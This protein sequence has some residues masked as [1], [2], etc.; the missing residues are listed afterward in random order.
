MVATGNELVIDNE[1]V[2]KSISLGLRFVK[3]I[4]TISE[5]FV[6]IQ[7]MAILVYLRIIS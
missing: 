5:L 3:W 6:S 1:I 7:T 2:F 4:L